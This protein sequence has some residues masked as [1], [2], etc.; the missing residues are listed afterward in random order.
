MGR[1]K[2]K[3]RHEP[4]R[5]GQ[6]TCNPS[7]QEAAAEGLAQFEA[8]LSYKHPWLSRSSALAPRC[9]VNPGR[10]GDAGDSGAGQPCGTRW[11]AS[12]GTL[13]RDRQWETCWSLRHKLAQCPSNALNS[14]GFVAVVQSCKP[15]QNHGPRVR[16]SWRG[17]VTHPRLRRLPDLISE[18]L[19]CPC[20]SAWLPGGSESDSRVHRRCP[21]WPPLLLQLSGLVSGWVRA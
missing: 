9:S 20:L 12:L 21:E 1:T 18:P 6:H 19:A 11:S 16:F 7:A 17:W 13:R 2:S 5:A 4:A 15:F 8:I 14:S 3:L 10:A